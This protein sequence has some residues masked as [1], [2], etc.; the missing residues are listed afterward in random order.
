MHRLRRLRLGPPA[1]GEGEAHGWHQQQQQTPRS[2]PG[3]A[4]APTS[5]PALPADDT[6]ALAAHYGEFGF[7]VIKGMLS[8]LEASS[9]L[10]A[11]RELIDNAPAERGGTLD[12]D[13]RQ[14]KH[15]GAYAFTDPVT[16]DD[17]RTYLVPGQG[18]VLNR[19]SAPM[20]MAPAF[21]T[22]FGNP[23]MLRAVERIY[24]RDF[25]PFAESL[26]LKNPQDGAGFQFHQDALRDG[27]FEQGQESE[28]GLNCGI[29]ASSSALTVYRR[30]AQR[31]STSACCCLTRL[32]GDISRA[33]LTGS[34]LATGCLW[35]IPGT[36]R[37]GR[38]DIE[39]L[40]HRRHDQVFIAILI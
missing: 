6:A 32:F 22:V 24:G 5:F 14:C 20:P 31:V 27:P 38:I 21:R 17:A 16:A 12:R 29:C 4:A 10:A 39:N 36:H 23:R 11:A 28:L 25:C 37:R 34:S 15:P 3:A 13:G 33:D 19:I 9:V 7:V 26:V 2:V 35:V 40:P 8:Q 1:S 18:L 30:T